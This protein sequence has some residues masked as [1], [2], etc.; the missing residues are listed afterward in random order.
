[1]RLMKCRCSTRFT[2]PMLIVLIE[3]HIEVTSTHATT[4]KA[5]YGVMLLWLWNTTKAINLVWPKNVRLNQLTSEMTNTLQIQYLKKTWGINPLEKYVFLVTPICPT[6]NPPFTECLTI[7]TA[8][9]HIK[10]NLHA[11]LISQEAI[12]TFNLLPFQG[13]SFSVMVVLADND[14][15]WPVVKSR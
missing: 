8:I 7:C 14:N 2:N 9:E 13:A 1:M 5:F 4:K 15:L 6:L 12:W 10:T 3:M 11:E